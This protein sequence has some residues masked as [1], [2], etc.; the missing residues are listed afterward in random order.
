VHVRIELTEL[1]QS[2]LVNGLHEWGGP[3]RGTDALAVAMGFADLKDLFERTPALVG[4]IRAGSMTAD[5]W[6]RVV[7]ATEVVFASDVVGS[8]TDWETTT[9]LSDR[10]TLAALRAIQRKLPAGATT[11][12]RPHGARD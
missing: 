6:C 9:G 10:D 1:E 7:L 5:D 2:V 8:G 4:G 12:E 3:A 11:V